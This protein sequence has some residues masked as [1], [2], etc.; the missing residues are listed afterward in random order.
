MSES[1]K[2]LNI[3]ND[4]SAFFL[5]SRLSEFQSGSPA[6]KLLEIFAYGTWQD[7]CALEPSLPADLKIP[8]A[9]NA[10]NKLRSLT[11]LTLFAE[12]NVIKFETLRS[13]LSLRT[14]EEVEGVLIPLLASDLLDGKIDEEAKAVVCSR[15]SARCVRDTEKDVMA[16]VT[17]IKNI[18]ANIKNALD[19]SIPA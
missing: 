1:K 19:M 3:L 2:L 15:A 9:G 6:Y 13:A 12:E 17:N 8:K 10:A 11:L 7:Y 18:R 4:S 16:V 5:G 14:D